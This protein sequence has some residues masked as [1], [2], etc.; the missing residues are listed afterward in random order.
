MIKFKNFFLNRPCCMWSHIVILKN[1]IFWIN[2]YR[3][4]F[5]EFFFHS[6]Q[7]LYVSAIIVKFDFK[8]DEYVLIIPY[9]IY[10]IKSFFHGLLS[11]LVG[12]VDPYQA[13]VS[14]ERYCHRFFIFHCL[15]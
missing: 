6:L 7:L 9:T 14:Y 2:E 4:L 15:L 10:T 8:N 1:D 12:V 11:D 3:T 13:I 5:I